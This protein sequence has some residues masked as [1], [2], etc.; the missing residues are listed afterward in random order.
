MPYIDLL[1][2]KARIFDHWKDRLHAVGVSI[3]WGEPGCWACGFHYGVKYDIKSS[4]ASW[5]EIFDG[6]ERIPLQRCHI[7]PGSL[8]GSD[9]PGNLFLMCRECH[10]LAPNTVIPEI[11]FEWVR[12][13]SFVRREAA[14]IDE[15]FF[16]FGVRADQHREIMEIMQ[17]VEFG[18]WMSGKSGLHR[19]QSNYASVLS[20]LTPATLIGLAI[21]YSRLM[22][23]VV[24]E[25]V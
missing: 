19:P 23:R 21:H 2:S 25:R 9:L 1:P 16:S 11:F 4:G 24:E 12:A 14:K 3:D 15:A 6:W 7:V 8:G 5:S 17:S 13:Q 10:D 20:R 18:V 22:P